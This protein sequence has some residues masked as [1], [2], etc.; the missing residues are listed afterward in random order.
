MTKELRSFIGKLAPQRSSRRFWLLTLAPTVAVGT[1][2]LWGIDRAY[3]HD[4]NRPDLKAWFQSLRS[5]AGEPCC[6]TGDAEHAEATWDMAK[7]GHKVLLRN[8]QKPNEVGE[9]FDV[10]DSAVVD[11]PNLDGFAMVWW[12]PSYDHDGTMTPRW[13]CLIPGAAG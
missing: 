4:S 5:K 9:W 12:W 11:R 3:A 10:P 6:D 2:P 7:R 8:P 1:L 13:R